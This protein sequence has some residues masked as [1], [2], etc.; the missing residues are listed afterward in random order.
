MSIERALNKT[1]RRSRGSAGYPQALLRCLGDAAPESVASRGNLAILN[2]HKLAIFCS[3]K[4]PGGLILQ[5]YDVARALRDAGVTV[6]SGFHSSMEEEC[7]T[8]LLRGSQSIIICPARGIERMRVPREWREPLAEGRLLI[9]SPFDGRHRRTTAT[10]ARRRNRFAAALADSVLVAHAESGGATEALCREVLAWGKPLLAL[11]DEANA[12]L[13]A[14]GATAVPPHL[15]RR[16]FSSAT[17]R[18]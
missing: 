12:H 1:A 14:L 6:I 15:N 17:W 4:C 7:L 11:D 5:T 13:F 9:L 18:V 16:P 8:L 3:R 2:G 10:R